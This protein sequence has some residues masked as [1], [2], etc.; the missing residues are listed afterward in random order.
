MSAEV[1]LEVVQ[2]TSKQREYRYDQ[3][4]TIIVGRQPDCKIALQEMT[5]SRYHCLL[6]LAP[7]LMLLQDFGSQNGTY[8]IHKGESAVPSLLSKVR[9]RDIVPL[10]D[11]DTVYLGLDCALR[12]CL[13][14]EETQRR[15]EICNALFVS[16]NPE[17]FFCESCKKNRAA[18]TKS[19]LDKLEPLCS[20]RTGPNIHGYTTE[21]ML[22]EGASGEAWL[23]IDD[24]NGE[25]VV[26]KRLSRLSML[27]EKKRR[28]FLREVSV[29]SQLSHPNVIHQIG[30]GELERVPYLLTEYCPGGSLSDYARRK[31]LTQGRRLEVPTAT[32][33][34]FQLLDALAYVHTA[35]VTSEL[36]DGTVRT[37]QGI[38]HRDIN[39][40]NIF[41]MDETDFPTI[42]LADFGFAKAFETAGLTRY[43]V[44]Q[45]K[46]G[47]WDF[48]PRIQ[49]NDY[50]YS[51]PD[52]DVWAAAATYYSMLTG[53]PPKNTI[54]VNNAVYVA[55]HSAATPIRK[56]NP[57]LPPRL[58]EAIDFA[59]EEKEDR[60]N[61]QSALAFKQLIGGAI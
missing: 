3:S 17:E 60:L 49:I 54:G 40:T 27:S 30:S 42:R 16:E 24:K 48:I 15:C 46:M 44:N 19:L 56:R 32:H 5:V 25:P 59:L 55:L 31:R 2:G 47:T 21:K 26:C 35:Q 13:V 39:P 4:E 36:S 11:G 6:E 12:V 9:E 18:I 22:G 34:L 50:R 52:V 38:V 37:V 41:L 58:A 28:R 51:K 45:E 1:V 43:T 20:I 10:R 57:D 53:Y 29:V 23:L 7:P 33:I 14:Q 61:V 8:L